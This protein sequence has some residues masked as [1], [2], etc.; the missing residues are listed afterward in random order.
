MATRPTG[1]IQV[2]SLRE[3]R[4]PTLSHVTE[5]PALAATL[6][7]S[8]RASLES[9]TRF[10]HTLLVGPPDSG[11]QGLASTVADE[12]GVPL[13]TVSMEGMQGPNELHDILVTVPSGAVVL[14]GSL[15]AN[16]HISE[17]L[18]R[19]ARGQRVRKMPQVPWDIPGEGW[20]QDAAE[21]PYKDFTII[22]T[23]R[24]KDAENYILT[25]WAE[26]VLYTSRT[27]ETEVTRIDRALRRSG[28]SADK[29]ALARF[30]EFAVTSEV[31]T[32]RLARAV[33]LWAI[34]HESPRLDAEAADRALGEL[35]ELLVGPERRRKT[36]EGKLV[37]VPRPGSGW[38][39]DAEGE[40]KQS[41][42]GGRG[43]TPME[44]ALMLF[45]VAVLLAVV[46]ASGVLVGARI[47]RWI[48]GRNDRQATPAA[49][50]AETPTDGSVETATGSPG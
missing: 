8:V 34:Q 43:P 28:I 40:A 24:D 23:T 4:A 1:Q 25:G 20:K 41:K 31:R 9:G 29:E 49:E 26:L 36:P 7:Q 19:V 50:S 42:S 21:E 35:I 18:C 30:A 39:G 15:E 12:L 16:W 33:A 13:V 11:K 17:E 47:D 10:P 32:L 37:G 6:A 44:V 48:D 3:L 22:A 38:N 46:V 27:K 14:V 5:A 2:P 45:G